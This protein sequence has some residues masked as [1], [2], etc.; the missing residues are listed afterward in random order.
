MEKY[1]QRKSRKQ[2]L[3]RRNYGTEESNNKLRSALQAIGEAGQDEREI[4]GRTREKQVFCLQYGSVY[5]RQHQAQEKEEGERKMSRA[6]HFLDKYRFQ[7]EEMAKLGCSD[8]HI[9]KVLHDI[10]KAEF[11]TETLI[12]Y[13]DE[14]GIRKRR[15]AKRWTR[16]KEVEWEGLCK[17]LRRK[18]GKS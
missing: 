2:A 10:Q 13:M 15:A 5:V 8:E 1:V 11:P 14:N 4:L 17:Q 16:N 3:V 7:I 18:N 9:H 6:A 12:R